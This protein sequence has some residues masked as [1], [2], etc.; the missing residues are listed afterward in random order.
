MSTCEKIN[1]I[2]YAH[3]AEILRFRSNRAL[4][5][6]NTYVTKG[7]LLC[8]D[9]ITSYVKSAPD[10]FEVVSEEKPEANFKYRKSKNYIV[11]DPIDG[12]ENFTSGLKEWGVS[13]SIY[14]QGKHE[15]S[16]ITMPELNLQLMTNDNIPRYKSRICGISSSLT[17]KDL[18]GLRDDGVE[19]RI[20]GCCV[21]NMYN[22]ITGSFA[23]F[24]NSK[25]AHVWDILAGLNLALEHELDVAVDGK[26]Y[27][28]EFL[29]PVKKYSFKIQRQI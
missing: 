4:K 1:K 15:E 9:I 12:T 20:M 16:M 8:Q 25:G 2:I 13:V 23:V 19:Y 18:C 6:D 10:E 14:R 22:V 11:L 29:P 17:K 27:C 21:Y 24:E 7:D 3:L 5:R 26:K 28:G